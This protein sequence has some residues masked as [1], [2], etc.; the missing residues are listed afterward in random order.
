MVAERGARWPTARMETSYGAVE[1]ESGQ[2]EIGALP[3]KVV[4]QELGEWCEDEGSEAWS[5]DGDAGGEG[6]LLL[7]VIADRH[8][9]RQVDQSEADAAQDAVRDHQHCHRVGER[10]QCER[11]ATDHAAHDARRP[12][13]ELVGYRAHDRTFLID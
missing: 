8:D 2:D 3:V 11:Q 6:A 7:K 9:G 12:A 13:A 4:E 1:N 10:A 5:A